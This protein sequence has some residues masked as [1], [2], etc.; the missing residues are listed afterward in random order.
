MTTTLEQFLRAT[1]L[2]DASLLA[3]QLRNSTTQEKAVITTLIE[4]WND[5]QAIANLLM[6][7]YLIPADVR[8]DTLRKGLHQLIDSYYVL[9]A[10]V[11]LQRYDTELPENDHKVIINRLLKIIQASPSVLAVQAS[12][13][14][15]TLSRPDDG[16]AIVDLLNQTD[17]T[18]RHNGLAALVTTCRLSTQSVIDR[19]FAD[20]RLS[21]AAKTYAD[22]QLK[23][24]FPLL[25]AAELDPD[26]WYLSD[27]SAPS[28]VS[29]PD[30]HEYQSSQEL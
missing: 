17:L 23:E 21:A 11:G 27:L 2:D 9:A 1:T 13:A 22:Q 20:G 8:W 3:R 7:P 10:L 29:I 28:L 5:E 25:N 26:Q 19:A 16:D 4:Q 6:H 18:I 24:A 15:F 14:L 12:T 30:L